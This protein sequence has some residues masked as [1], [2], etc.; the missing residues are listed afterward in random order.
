MIRERRA[1][2]LAHRALARLILFF[3]SN[4]TDVGLKERHLTAA[5]ATAT[6]IGHTAWLSASLCFVLLIVLD[7][8][9]VLTKLQ[10]QLGTLARPLRRRRMPTDWNNL[11]PS[12][13]Q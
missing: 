3:F 11:S 6:T 7:N 13:P 5:V 10:T 2:R 4:T 12:Y 8:T 9:A 1:P